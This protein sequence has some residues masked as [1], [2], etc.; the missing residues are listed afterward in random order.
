MFIAWLE[1][2][3]WLACRNILSDR[4]SF[5]INLKLNTTPFDMKNAAKKAKNLLDIDEINS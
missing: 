4:L 3:C 1:A 2:N 5:H